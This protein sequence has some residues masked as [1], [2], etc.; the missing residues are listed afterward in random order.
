MRVNIHKPKTI[1][2]L[3]VHCIVNTE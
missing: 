1:E 2:R 3:Y